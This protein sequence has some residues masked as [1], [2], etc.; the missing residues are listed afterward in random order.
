[1]KKIAFIFPGQGVQHVGMSRDLYDAYPAVRRW[2]D[3]AN[4]A[5]GIELLRLCFEGPEEELTRTCNAQPAILA[6]SVAALIPLQEALSE[7]GMPQPSYAAGLSLGEYTALVCAGSLTALDAVRLVRQRGLF[8]EEAGAATGGTMASILGLDRP[9][10]DTICAEVGGM[11]RA[12]NYN[13]PGQIVLSGEPDAVARAGALAKE[14]GARRVIPLKVS[15]AFH[16]PLMQPA[17][18]RLVVELS[19]TA[20]SDADI[21]VVANVTGKPVHTAAEIRAALEAQVTG[22]VLW[23]D[24]VRLMAANGVTTFVEVGPGQV[25]SGLVRRI[26]P[27]AQTLQAGDVAGIA[28]TVEALKANN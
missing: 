12:A 15:G 25:L 1:M 20:I 22:S 4:Q 3:T 8:M 7:C 23:E 6:A 11:V 9:T 28:A 24:S 2:M 5:S 14:R 13:A 26:V 17:A 16:S 21:P 19:R 27:E 10:V 18:D